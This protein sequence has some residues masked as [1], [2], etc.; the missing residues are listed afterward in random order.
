MAFFRKYLLLK[1]R[2]ENELTKDYI[3]AGL[4]NQNCDS[5]S[6]E[7]LLAA[8]KFEAFEKKERGQ[9]GHLA[10]EHSDELSQQSNVALLSCTNLVSNHK[11][12]PDLKLPRR[13]RI[14]GIS[15]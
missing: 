8:S 7:L 11:L 14:S 5:R 6:D 1:K 3:E 9:Q 15:R 4:A 12:L 10:D 2:I 13:K